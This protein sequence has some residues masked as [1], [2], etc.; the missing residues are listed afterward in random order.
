MGDSIERFKMEADFHGLVQLLARNLYSSSDVFV[1]E[2]IQNAHDAICLRRQR[3]PRLAGRIDMTVRPETREIVFRDNGLGMSRRDI[4]R[5]LSVIGSSGTGEARERLGQLGAHEAMELIGRFG[6]GLLSA[7]LVADSVQ[8]RTRKLGA[9][10][11]FLWENDGSAECSLRSL[12]LGWIGT[13]VIVRVAASHAHMLC[14]DAL[15][16]A[17]IRY[18]DFVPDPI[19][20]NGRGPINAMEAPWHRADWADDA[21][22]GDALRHFL[23][24]RYPDVAV[25]VMPVHLEAPVRARGALFVTHNRIPDFNSAGVVDVYV[26]RMLVRAADPDLLP[27]WAKFVRGVVD[28]P[29]LQPNSARDNVRRDEAFAEL[30]AALGRVVLEHLT[31]LAAE[32]PDRMA[33]LCRW[34]HWHLKGIAFFDEAFFHEVSDL[35]FFDSNRGP[36]CLRDLLANPQSLEPTGAVP[37]HMVSS[38]GASQYYRVAESRDWTVLDASRALDEALLTKFEQRHPDR[39]TLVH[40]DAEEVDELFTLLAPDESQSFRAVERSMEATL[41]RRE[42]GSFRVRVRRF[43]PESVPALVLATPESEAEHQLEA[44]AEA[45]WLSEELAQL[46]REVARSRIRPLRLMLNAAHPL[47]RSL[48][49]LDSGAPGV[50]SIHLGLAL[51]ALLYSRKLLSERNVPLLQESLVKLLSD[52]AGRTPLPP[53]LPHVAGGTQR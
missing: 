29:D 49:E 33:R 21:R 26:R 6:I 4:R 37:I 25:E 35:L 39:M 15:E 23:E 1:R 11:G 30:Q 16:A 41:R 40:L 14:A 32:K 13:E 27:P 34:H 44:L 22:R 9:R 52:F 42:L 10:R 50:A 18:S 47:I 12:D 17:V 20:L 28:S 53:L 5:F 46:T 38:E 51:S 8:V 48:R 7:F 3:E 2:L 31:R 45:P 24:R 19:S 43:A 36:V